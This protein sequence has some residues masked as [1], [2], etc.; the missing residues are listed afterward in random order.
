[1]EDSL[2]RD[3]WPQSLRGRG[4][5]ASSLPDFLCHVSV[6]A[7][8]AR[9]PVFSHLASSLRGLSTIQAYKAEQKFQ[10]LFDA[11]QDLHSGLSVSGDDFKE[12]NVLPSEADLPLRWPGCPHLSLC[13]PSSPSAHLPPPPLPLSIPSVLPSSLSSPAFLP[14]LACIVLASLCP[15]NFCLFRA[16]ISKLLFCE[17]P[18]RKYCRLY[19]LYTVSVATIHLCCC[20]TKTGKVINERMVVPVFH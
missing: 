14:W 6:S 8:P 5:L 15:V 2:W 3:M 16:R 9:S 7:S 1:M 13:H 17:D 20:S 10:E 4:F 12:W 19:V 18:D 11:H